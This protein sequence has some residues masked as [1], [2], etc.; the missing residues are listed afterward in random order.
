VDLPEG[1]F[2]LGRRRMQLDRDQHQRQAEI[3]RPE[4][5]RHDAELDII[6]E[7]ESGALAYQRKM[8]KRRLTAGR[9]QTEGARFGG[10]PE[11]KDKWS[12]DVSRQWAHPQGAPGPKVA[13]PRPGRL[14]IETL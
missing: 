7:S 8:N 3:A 10:R 14:A 2:A 5:R 12:F 13:S 1:D 9:T 11:G 6:L 4:G